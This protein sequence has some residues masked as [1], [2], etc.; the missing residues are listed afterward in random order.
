M[1][2]HQYVV[3]ALAF[4]DITII[5]DVLTKTFFI[6]ATIRITVNGISARNEPITVL[7]PCQFMHFRLKPERD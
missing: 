1:R 3:D 6:I 4:F 7:E 2:N 5:S